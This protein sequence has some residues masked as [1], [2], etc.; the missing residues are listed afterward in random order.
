MKGNSNAD[1]NSNMHNAYHVIR[2]EMVAMVAMVAMV[3]MMMMRRTTTTMMM[4]NNFAM[5]LRLR[6]S[7]EFMAEFPF[8]L[9]R[10]R[11]VDEHANLTWRSYCRG[12]A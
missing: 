5:R 9:R 4:M 3:M 10:W 12:Q 2:V 11:G 7:A 1:D 8:I 6:F